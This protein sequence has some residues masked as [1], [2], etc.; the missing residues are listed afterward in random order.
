MPINL[1]SARI[2]ITGSSGWLGSEALCYLSQILGPLNRLNLVCLS[3]DGGSFRIHDETIQPIAFMDLQD[4]GGFDIIIHFAFLLPG[5]IETVDFPNYMSVNSSITKKMNRV[6]KKNPNALKLVLS[7]GAVNLDPRSA[8]SEITLL[9]AKSKLEME[10]I[11]QDENTI[12]LRLWSTTGHHLPLTSS[13]AISDFIN[14]A[15]V[16]QDILI[17]NNVKR[18]YIGFQDIFGS[19][20]EFLL[21]K[22]RGIYNS[23]G[24]V[25]TLDSLAELVITA[26]GS[27]SK[28]HLSDIAQD[29]RLDYFSPACEIPKSYLQGHL[30]LKS[31]VVNTIATVNLMD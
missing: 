24:E 12:I 5:N 15:V 20:M 8:P 6:F 4:I 26:L 29:A 17:Q 25:S 1:N 2:L 27:K 13:Y 11:L 31:Q 14:S 21:N 28:V 3:K 19:T 22:G 7:S 18:S 16:D 30:S 23:G 10:S 9:Y